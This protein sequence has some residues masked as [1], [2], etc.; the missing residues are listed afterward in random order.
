MYQQEVSALPA[1]CM[2]QPSQLRWLARL[3]H[4]GM[5]S[6]PTKEVDQKGLAIM[7]AAKK[8]AGVTP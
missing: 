8:S 2:R 5:G 4:S 1:V 3:S 7:L 6:N